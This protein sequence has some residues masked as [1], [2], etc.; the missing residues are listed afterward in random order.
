MWYWGWFTTALKKHQR[1]ASSVCSEHLATTA[2]GNSG[3]WIKVI[4]TLPCRNHLNLL[5]CK[6][7]VNSLN[8]SKI[9]RLKRRSNLSTRVSLVYQTWNTLLKSVKWFYFHNYKKMIPLLKVRKLIQYEIVWERKR[10][11][12]NRM[13]SSQLKF[14][15]ETMM[16]WKVKRLMQIERMW[17]STD[18]IESE[19]VKTNWDS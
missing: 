19:K 4:H 6:W 8:L 16:L 9:G 12:H 5:Y 18:M 10:K 17:E 1:L 2:I 3:Q 13:A 14:R 7:K 15:E 11:Y